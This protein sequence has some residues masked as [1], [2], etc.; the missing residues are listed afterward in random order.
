MGISVKR[1]FFALLGPL[2]ATEFTD[3]AKGPIIT[4]KTDLGE[5]RR[6][7]LT[8]TNWAMT[9]NTA[10]RGQNPYCVRFPFSYTCLLR[11]SRQTDPLVIKIGMVKVAFYGP[12]V[13]SSGKEPK[14]CC[15]FQSN[16]CIVAEKD[17]EKTKKIRF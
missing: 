11:G 9:S 2:K 4:A 8:A 14:N 1:S 17:L 7:Q 3:V 10:Q 13:A 6:S 5:T 12:K 16:L 15:L